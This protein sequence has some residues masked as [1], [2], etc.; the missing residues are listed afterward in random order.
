MARQ[1]THGDVVTAAYLNAYSTEL[2][3]L[4]ASIKDAEIVPC[5]P[6]KYGTGNV[7]RLVHE[8]RWLH[9]K[10]TGQIKNAG[11]T[12]QATLSPVN[13]TYTSFDLQSLSWLAYGDF[14][15]VVGCDMACEEETPL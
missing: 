2:T 14:Y 8:K 11:G 15:Q 1:W 6:H 7:Y 13:D 10:S 5:V 3:A 12:Q 4:R 9:F